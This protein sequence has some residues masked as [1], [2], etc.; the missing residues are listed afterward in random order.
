MGG[1]GEG[2]G[3]NWPLTTLHILLYSDLPSKLR[4]SSCSN[5]MDVTMVTRVGMFICTIL[6]YRHDR[7]LAQLPPLVCAGLKERE[8][9]STCLYRPFFNDADVLF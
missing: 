1:G 9:R 7:P 2:G 8:H 4:V 3:L 5:T 6:S